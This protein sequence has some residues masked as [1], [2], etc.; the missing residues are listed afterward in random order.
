MAFVLRT[1]ISVT[2][3]GEFVFLKQITFGNRRPFMVLA[4]LSG[5]DNDEHTSHWNES[6][7]VLMLRRLPLLMIFY[8]FL[9]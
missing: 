6:T 3:F 5:S 7:S 2:D 9:F 8:F 1:I 4:K